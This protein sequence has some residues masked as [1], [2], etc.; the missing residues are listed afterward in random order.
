[1]RLAGTRALVTGGTRGIGEAIAVAFVRE[2]ADV[3]VVSRKPEGVKAAVERIRR[4]A[5]DGGTVTGHPLHVGALDALG[6]FVDALTAEKPLDILV[7][8]AGTNPYFGP[9]LG[10]TPSAWAKTFEVN[11]RGPFELIRAFCQARETHGHTGPASIINVS[12]VLGVRASPLQ[13]VY[14][15]TKAALIAMTRTLAFELGP[16]GIRVN[17]IAPGIIRTRLSR[18]IVDDPALLARVTARTAENRVGEPDEVA[19]AAV[20]LASEASSYVTGQVL[21]VDGGYTAI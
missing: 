21:F 18:A 7:N 1:M 3:V 2:G 15:M 20:F 12:S 14:G 19:G 11:L 16:S 6:P 4:A 10:I 8:N 9:L 17:A 5:P 13:G